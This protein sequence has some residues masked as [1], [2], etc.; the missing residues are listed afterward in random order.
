M[1]VNISDNDYLTLTISNKEYD[2]IINK[3]SKYYLHE[4]CTQNEFVQDLKHVGKFI[5]QK[6]E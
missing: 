5:I 2:E 3:L 6:E 1:K 4:Y